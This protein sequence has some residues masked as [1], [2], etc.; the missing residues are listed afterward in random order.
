MA[1]IV[2]G[3]KFT[4]EE[5][6]NLYSGMWDDEV[7]IVVDTDGWEK[8]GRVRDLKN[9]FDVDFFEPEQSFYAVKVVQ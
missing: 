4:D 5:V 7:I 1:N 9:D 3:R 2:K 8:L 6:E